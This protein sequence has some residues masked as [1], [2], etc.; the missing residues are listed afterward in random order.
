MRLWT[1]VLVVLHNVLL[2]T[3]QLCSEV[4]PRR[5]TAVLHPKS[6]PD[7][8]RVVFKARMWEAHSSD[9]VP[10]L[11]RTVRRMRHRAKPCEQLRSDGEPH[12]Y[13]VPALLPETAAICGR[14]VQCIVGKQSSGRG[15]FRGWEPCAT[16]PI[17]ENFLIEIVEIYS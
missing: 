6:F 17:F 4:G 7:F 1:I 11:E 8:E 3:L 13:A 2:A 5:D 16:G 9:C 10:R 15:R 12:S 14:S